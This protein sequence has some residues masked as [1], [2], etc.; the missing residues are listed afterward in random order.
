MFDNILSS[1]FYAICNGIARIMYLTIL[2][3]LASL[4]MIT[5]GASLT[6]LIA[7]SR[8]PECNVFSL[9]WQTFTANILRGT[10]VLIF[11]VFSMLSLME[12]WYFANMIPAGNILVILVGIFLI[13]YNLNAY[14]FVSILKRCGLT[15]FRQ[16]F[17][18][19]IGTIYK[20]FLVPVIAVI[21]AIVTPIIG[22][23]PLL[24][25]SLPIVLTIYVKLVK[26]DLETVEE[27]L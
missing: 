8:Q 3:M 4:P 26:N 15:F 27:L 18:F 24:L 7:T 1:R 19:T 9:F 17:F 6:A 5:I 13:V 20:T 16:V 2:F 22:D 14:L 23:I 12:L 21:F 11:T 10:V 25:M